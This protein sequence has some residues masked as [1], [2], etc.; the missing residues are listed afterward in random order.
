MYF[1]GDGFGDF[2]GEELHSYLPFAPKDLS[3]HIIHCSH[4]KEGRSCTQALDM[5]KDVSKYLFK[6][7]IDM[8]NLEDFDRIKDH[9]ENCVELRLGISGLVTS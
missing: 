8:S 1:T 2:E 4:L 7:K 3:G 6:S 5:M 9:L